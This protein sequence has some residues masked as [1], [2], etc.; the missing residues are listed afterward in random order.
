ME[1][2]KLRELKHIVVNFSVRKKAS[3]YRID[4]S[5]GI[6]NALRDL[7]NL[8]MIEPVYSNGFYIYL[9][10]VKDFFLK[11]SASEKQQLGVQ[12]KSMVNLS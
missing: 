8:K 2:I 3:A 4:A 9:R 12:I 7:I 11:L 5:S 6:S 1:A 10:P